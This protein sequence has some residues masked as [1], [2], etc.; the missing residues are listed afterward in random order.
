MVT[1]LYTPALLRKPTAMML[2]VIIRRTK[3][4]EV[5]EHAR[6]LLFRF[7]VAE[8]RFQARLK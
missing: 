7:A 2:D 3:Q 6:K 1:E 4:P 8:A 5:R